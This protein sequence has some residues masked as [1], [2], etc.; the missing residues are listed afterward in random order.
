MKWVIDYNSDSIKHLAFLLHGEK[1]GTW[2]CDMLKD[3][4]GAPSDISNFC[5]C[6]S[7]VKVECKH[8]FIFTLN[9]PQ[10]FN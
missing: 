8:K 5:P 7:L 10:K 2:G 6:T 3:S 9:L 1:M 4:H